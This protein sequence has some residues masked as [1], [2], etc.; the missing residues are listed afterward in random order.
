MILFLPA[1]SPDFN[2]IEESFSTCEYLHS[3]RVDDPFL[4]LLESTACITAEMAV[5]W[6]KHAGYIW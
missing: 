5:G 4:A 2:P 6:F 3:L 1:Y